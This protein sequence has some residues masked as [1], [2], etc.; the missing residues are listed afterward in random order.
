MPVSFSMY[1]SQTM[2]L[3]HIIWKFCKASRYRKHKSVLQSYINI[4]KRSHIIGF[5]ITFPPNVCSIQCDQITIYWTVGNF[6]KPSATINLPKSPTFLG[7]FCKGVKV[8]NFSFEF[9]LGNFFRHLV[10][11]YWSNWFHIPTEDGYWSILVTLPESNI[12]IMSRFDI[13]VYV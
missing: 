13:Q 11:F 9:I 7:I 2:Y 3:R 10:T 12:F 4:L 5:K 6:L 1:S 8:F